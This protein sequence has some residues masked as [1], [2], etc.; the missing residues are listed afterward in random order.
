MSD[1]EWNLDDEESKKA[2]TIQGDVPVN[3]SDTGKIEED[4]PAKQ[5][6]SGYEPEDTRKENIS[7][8]GEELL[9][10][11][12]A[13]EPSKM[14]SQQ[15]SRGDVRDVAAKGAGTMKAGQVAKSDIRGTQ[16][17]QLS[18]LEAAAKGETPSLAEM[19]AKKQGDRALAQ[20]LAMAAG[21]RGGQAAVARRTAAQQQA[22]IGQDIAAT[23]AQ[24][25]LQEQQ[26]AE[27]LLAG[28]A[29]QA[30]GQD[31]DVSTTQAQLDTQAAAANL[32]AETQAAD[33]DLRAQLAN[34]GVDL[35]VL[36]DNAARGDATALANIQAELQKLGMDN[37][38]IQAYLDN[39]VTMRGQDMGLAQIE[40]S[41][42][43]ARKQ[44]QAQREAAYIGTAGTL[45]ST[46]MA[47][48]DINAKENIEK[49][50][51]GKALAGDRLTDFL[52]SLDTY[53]YNYKEPEK[54]GEGEQTSVMA[55][56]LEK[57]DIGQK[58]VSE[59]IE[60]IKRVDYSK[61][62]PEMLAANVDANKRISE[63][64]KALLAKKKGK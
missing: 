1:S 22:A 25:R 49:R 56:D 55:Q 61:L 60:G 4:K 58:A 29:G 19:A 6:T 9:N 18:R 32:T 23:A 15:I 2:F 37:N 26:Q 30:R 63:L 31:I 44:A 24:A 8:V 48:S 3:I 39:E 11:Q 41:E 5:E 12:L 62:L 59:D 10:R 36:K 57:S 33:R 47:A 17:S 28:A 20:Q 7:R 64:E 51:I 35:N 42:K 40:S 45:F 34:Q 16:T 52:N 14:E 27:Q 50:D 13:K 53:N 46:L 38:M 21:A 54:H 43:L